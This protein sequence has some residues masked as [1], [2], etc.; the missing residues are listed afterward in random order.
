MKLVADTA[1]L[2]NLAQ[3]QEA[4]AMVPDNPLVSV[5]L[6][7]QPPVRRE[8]R[9]IPVYVPANKLHAVLVDLRTQLAHTIQQQLAEESKR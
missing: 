6:A 8:G 9:V 7:I 4:L 1:L 5:E 3:V 2:K